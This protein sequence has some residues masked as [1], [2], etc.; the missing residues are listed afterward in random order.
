MDERKRVS[1]NQERKLAKRSG[2]RLHAGSGSGHRR[3]DMHNDDEVIE[4]KTTLRGKKQITLKKDDLS[5]VERTAVSQGRRPVL[6]IELANRG[7]VVL[8]EEDYAELVWEQDG[9]GRPG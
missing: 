1:L 7:Y 8:T 4:C 6:H 2:S 3:N 5:L 9:S